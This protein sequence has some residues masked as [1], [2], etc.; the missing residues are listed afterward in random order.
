MVRCENKLIAT[1][2]FL[3]LL[4]II[5]NRAS[6]ACRG[7]TQI[8]LNVCTMNEFKSADRELNAYYTK[9]AKTNELVASQT[10]WN[11]YRE[12]ECAYQA[13][14]VEGGSMAP[15]VLSQCLTEL[16][17]QRLKQLIKDQQF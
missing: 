3:A 6:A 9:L 13:K 11:G 8:E 12:A 5:P 17:K 10:A 15:M 2:L 14:F 4:T 1:V 16:T 7:N